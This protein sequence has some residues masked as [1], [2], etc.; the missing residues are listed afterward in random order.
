MVL[1][2]FNCKLHQV[3]AH[4]LYIHLSHLITLHFEI[5]P[6]SFYT[7]SPSLFLY[8]MVLDTALLVFML[9]LWEWSWLEDQQR[10]RQRSA[11]TCLL[12]KV[13]RVDGSKLMVM[14]FDGRIILQSSRWSMHRVA[15]SHV[16]S[17]LC[18]F[19]PYAIRALKACKFFS[20]NR[21]SKSWEW[22]HSW[23][24]LC[25]AGCNCRLLRH[26]ISLHSHCLLLSFEFQLLVVAFI[27]ELII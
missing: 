15:I 3:I 5:Y 17:S 25:V 8:H 4:I 27:V 7:T 9:S 19:S 11:S 21:R 14:Y 2:T 1:A 6:C 13:T 12:A 22:L 10:V 24:V 18:W 16:Q 26:S 23:K 20:A